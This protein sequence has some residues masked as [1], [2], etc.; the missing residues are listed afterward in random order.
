MTLHRHISLHMLIAL[1]EHKIILSPIWHGVGAWTVHCGWRPSLPVQ[2]WL[3]CRWSFQAGD[4][5]LWNRLP[6]GRPSM[7]PH[8]Q[9]NRTAHK[10]NLNTSSHLS[11]WKQVTI[12]AKAKE[13]LEPQGQGQGQGH[14]LEDS[15]SASGPPHRDHNTTTTMQCKTKTHKIQTQTQMNLSSR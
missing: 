8:S 1:Q 3:S 11:K 5:V 9:L 4:G 7:N 6:A 10:W 2:R 12:K 13:G 14:L 15:Y